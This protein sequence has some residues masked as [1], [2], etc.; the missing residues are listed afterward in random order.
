MNADELRLLSGFGRIRY[1][2]DGK[3]ALKFRA[4]DPAN[5]YVRCGCGKSDCWTQQ[6]VPIRDHIVALFRAILS[7]GFEEQFE[8][9]NRSDDAWPGVTYALQMAASLDDV[10]VDPA[11]VD[12]S[13]AGLWCSSAWESDEDDREAGS[14]YVAALITFNFVWNAY[15]AA[16]EISAGRL[17]PKDKMPVRG[18]RLFQTEPQ[19]A[20]GVVSFEP[21]YRVARHLC[22]RLSEIEGDISA[23][24]KKYNLAGAAAAAEL[25]RIF[26]NYIVHGSDRDAINGGRAACARFYSITRLLL[27]LIQLLVLRRLK[28]PTT[29]VPLS[30]NRSDSGNQPAGHLLH[31]LHRR[32]ALWI[33]PELLRLMH[34]DED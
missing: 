29:P 2:D 15:E 32:E 14:K 25:G 11:Y 6:L 26:R 13:E 17:F 22:G 24:D 12:D 30:V 3:P 16:I 31:N 27:L 10:F 4:T 34:S 1:D 23:I 19:L 18:R 28:E 5:H 21:S 8:D 33:E 9:F 20:V 7:C